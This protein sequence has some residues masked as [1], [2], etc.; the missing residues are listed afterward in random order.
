MKEEVVD[1][2]AVG[3][4]GALYNGFHQKWALLRASMYILDFEKKV[5]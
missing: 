2:S 3:Q 1:G 4:D 5:L